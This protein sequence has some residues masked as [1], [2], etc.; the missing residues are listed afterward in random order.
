MSNGKIFGWEN[1]ETE[2]PNDRKVGVKVVD[3]E[4]MQLIWAEF[5]P[6]SRYKLHSHPHEQ[7]SFMVSGRMKLTVGKETRE[8]GA[9]EMW[10]APPNVMHGGELIGDEPVVFIDVYSPPNEEFRRDA[11]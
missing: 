1:I 8:I 6:G 4:N 10:H 3:G 5:Q 2:Y 9:G 11:G 7:F